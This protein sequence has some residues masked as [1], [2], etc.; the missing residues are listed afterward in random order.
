MLGIFI[1]INQLWVILVKDER[2]NCDLELIIEELN[3]QIY[4]LKKQL[5]YAKE[6]NQL[7]DLIIKKLKGESDE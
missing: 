4:D 6:E 3:N 2:G 5:D 1:I 7:K